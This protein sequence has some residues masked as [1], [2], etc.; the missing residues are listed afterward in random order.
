MDIL[1]YCELSAKLGRDDFWSSPQEV[2]RV[3]R[4]SRQG[5]DLQEAGCEDEGVMR[6]RPYPRGAFRPNAMRGLAT[7]YL[8][9]LLAQNHLYLLT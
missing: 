8:L 6:A 4:R 7:H 3:G 9:R 5:E 1:L 2:V